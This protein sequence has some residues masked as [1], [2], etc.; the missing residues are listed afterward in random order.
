MST[1]RKSFQEKFCGRPAAGQPIEILVVSL[2]QQHPKLGPTIHTTQPQRLPIEG[3]VGTF[4][5][6]VES[7]VECLRRR[8]FGPLN[9]SYLWRIH[10]LQKMWWRTSKLVKHI[11]INLVSVIWLIDHLH[12]SVER[13]RQATHARI[14][15]GNHL[16]IWWHQDKEIGWSCH[17]QLEVL[18]QES[19]HREVSNWNGN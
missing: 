10:W 16:S 17:Q 6:Q 18:H 3:V 12:L 9:H 7:Q 1:P 19:Q 15:V 8:K 5:L 2:R 11:G 13:I 4:K 14:R